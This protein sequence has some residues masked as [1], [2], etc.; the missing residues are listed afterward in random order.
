VAGRTSRSTAARQAT[1]HGIGDNMHGRVFGGFVAIQAS[2]FFGLCLAHAS[3]RSK[4]NATAK[5][6]KGLA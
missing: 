2:G 4:N 1:V 3:Q 5:G 6:T